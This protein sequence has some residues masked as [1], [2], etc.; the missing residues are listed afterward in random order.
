MPDPNARIL[1]VDDEASITDAVA[2]ALRYEGFCVSDAATGRTALDEIKRFRPDLVVLD[3]MLPDIDGLELT[4]RLRRERVPVPVLFLTARDATEDKI[5]G[6]TTGADDY[7]TKPFSLGEIIARIRAILRRTG[8]GDGDGV[9]RF[10]DLELDAETHEV[11]RAG[12]PIHLTAR[13]LDLLRYFLLNPRRVLSK[14]Q[15]LAAVW[16]DD[17]E[18]DSNVVETLVGYLRRKLDRHGPPLIRTIRGAGY[19]LR[20]D[21]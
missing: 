5:L 18:P 20:L 15:I 6:L 9:L 21:D 11:F 10:G 8:F 4:R 12:E 16:P 19:T 1:V 17:A 3:I 7:L 13:E 2:T 14:A